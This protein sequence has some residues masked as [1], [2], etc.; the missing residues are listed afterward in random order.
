MRRRRHTKKFGTQHQG[1]DIACRTGGRHGAFRNG[2]QTQ[3]VRG[4]DLPLLDGQPEVG[5]HGLSAMTDP[6]VSLVDIGLRCPLRGQACSQADQC[7]LRRRIRAHG[8]LRD[9]VTE[10]VVAF[11]WNHQRNSADARH[12]HVSQ[13]D[14]DDP[15]EVGQRSSGRPPVWVTPALANSAS[16]C[17]CC[18]TYGLTP[19]SFWDDA[20]T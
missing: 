9:D 3:P 15:V 17:T 7:G 16:T 18:C 11:A 8:A 4:G 13:V 20:D 1:D 14:S 2:R 6:V 10:P 5:P 19:V 12:V